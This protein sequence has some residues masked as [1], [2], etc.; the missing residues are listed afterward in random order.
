M[1]GIP[2]PA[3]RGQ[4]IKDAPDH[5]DAELLLRLYDLRREPT[6]RDAR[7]YMAGEFWP[8]SAADALALTKTDH[9]HNPAFRQFTSYW[10]MAYGMA[11][12]G[13]VNPDYLVEYAGE[14]LYVFAKVQPWLTELREGWSPRAF[15]NIEWIATE[16]AEGRAIFAQFR[17]RV[18]KAMAARKGS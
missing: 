17:Q 4:R 3:P 2:R 13:I 7:R 15:R 12:H 18:E 14:G 10:E 5:H 8:T 11:R 16:C 1:T 9:P 6:M